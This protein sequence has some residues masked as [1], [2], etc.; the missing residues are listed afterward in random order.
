M[1]AAQL[2]DGAALGRTH[3]GAGQATKIAHD[4]P[5]VDRVIA[6]AGFSVLD[7]FAALAN[8]GV[9]FVILKPWD[10][11]GKAKGPTSASIAEHLADS[12]RMICPTARLFVL[13]PPPIQGI[14]NAGGLQMQVELLGGSFDYSKLQDITQAMI[15][16]GSDSPDFSAS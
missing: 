6:I 10:E 11:R 7:N 4:T 12:A 13:V 15:E 8:A 2:P 3:G 9:N 5:G 1:I 14:G 16:A